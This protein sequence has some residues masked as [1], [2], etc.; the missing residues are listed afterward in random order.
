[1]GTRSLTKVIEVWQF[2]A[3]DGKEKRRRNTLV[4]IYRQF[5]GYP[6][7]LGLEL[8]Q[9]LSGQGGQNSNGTQDLA[10]LTVWHMKEGQWG[11]VYLY[12][13]RAKDV[14][15]EWE[16][17]IIGGYKRAVELVVYKIGYA[18]KVLEWRGHPSKFT[19]EVAQRIENKA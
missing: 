13:Y 11:N 19:Q 18:G 3:E 8:A 5:D 16:Y 1:M 6:T 7:G 2:T 15:E 9:F 4:N 10:A 12:P 14:G 17:H